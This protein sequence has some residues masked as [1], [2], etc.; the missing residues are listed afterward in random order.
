M[1]QQIAPRV[2]L[3]A[4][5]GVTDTNAIQVVNWLLNLKVLIS[6]DLVE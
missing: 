6:I 3:K 4:Y 1:E 2:K 5:I